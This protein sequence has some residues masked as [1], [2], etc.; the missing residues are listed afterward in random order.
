M[1]IGSLE[2]LPD[3]IISHIINYL[4]QQD[5]INLLYSNYHFYVLVQPLL[6][7]NL[8]FTRSAALPCR[9]TYDESLYTIVGVIRS[10][11]A[12]ASLN[13]KIFDA[14]QS[15]LLEAL[16]VNRQLCNYIEKIAFE[17]DYHNDGKVESLK[18]TVSQ[19]LL[20]FIVKNCPNL[21]SMPT[22]TLSDYNKI[23]P[24]LES[25]Q[26][27]SLNDIGIILDSSVK[28][29]FFNATDKLTIIDELNVGNIL[30]FFGRLETLAFNEE[31]SQS[32]ILDVIEKA[33]KTLPKERKLLFEFKHLK[34]LFYHCFDD[35]SNELRCFFKNINFKKL[36]K[37]ELVLGCDDM[38]CD[39]LQKFLNFLAE[40][41]LNLSNL[42]FIQKTAHREHNYTE[43]FDLHI[44][45]FLRQYPY[46]N[47][48][49]YLSIRHAPPND[50]NVG[51]G[52]E[53]N[54]LHRKSL[55]EAVLPL[56]AGLETFICPTFLESVAG[57]E[58]IISNL[59]WNGCKCE[60][61]NDYL[62][63]FDQY[64]LKHQYYDEV[65]S[66]MTDMISPILFGNVS[67]V[68]SSRLPYD[69]DMFLDKIT[70]ICRYWDFHTAPYRITH[71]EECSIDRSAFPPIA[72]CVA[73]FFQDYVDAIG[74]MI[75]TLKRCVLSGVYFD[76]C[77][78]K[79]D[80]RQW[81][82]SDSKLHEV[83]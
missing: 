57:Y 61:C 59:L 39:C 17:G 77:S 82:C 1:A 7:K 33:R 50:F 22:Y 18:D 6:Y 83:T 67:R 53:G 55:Y 31:L 41:D 58:Q 46:K 73:H 2:Q 65:K 42:S 48:L 12:T 66:H 9:H 4:P 14:R 40:Q 28:H 44:T 19:D 25:I 20:N 78:V 60:H 75:P 30:T 72:I 26:I 23:L 54:Y 56:L 52:F 35:P 68:L 11:L 64:I 27:S 5:K 36:K 45:E 34:L 13:S 43:K 62:P 79:G 69:C 71:S 49:K 3:H 24:K 81:K 80:P 21:K 10:P 16:T 8:L 47:S 32:I 70:P 29:V 51:D 74:N 76:R 37:L 15:I 38:T 63:I